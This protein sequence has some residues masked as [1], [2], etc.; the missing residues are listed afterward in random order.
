[1]LNSLDCQEM[2]ECDAMP[3]NCSTIKKKRRIDVFDSQR[4]K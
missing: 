1:M 2:C 4:L 3:F